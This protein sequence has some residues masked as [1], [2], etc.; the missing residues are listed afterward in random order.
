PRARSPPRRAG[1]PPWAVPAGCAP[2]ELPRIAGEPRRQRQGPRNRPW[3]RYQL[4]G[5]SSWS[6]GMEKNPPPRRGI[7]D[8]RS[9]VTTSG[10][11]GGRGCRRLGLGRTTTK[12]GSPGGSGGRLGGL[13]RTTGTLGG[14][15]RCRRLRGSGLGGTAALGDRLGAGIRLGGA[16]RF[17]GLGLAGGCRF[18]DHGLD[19]GFKGLYQLPRLVGFLLGDAPEL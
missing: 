13:C 12:I 16:G 4:Q 8:Q 7:L 5:V 10:L 11:G 9:D 2:G 14:R 17:G 18:L 6:G 19:L 15:F 1:R 3:W